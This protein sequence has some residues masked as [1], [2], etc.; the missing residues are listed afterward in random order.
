MKKGKSIF[1]ELVNRDR[2]TDSF[3]DMARICSPSRQERA[4][5]GFLRKEFEKLGIELHEDASAVKVGG[6]TGNLTGKFINPS[7]IKSAVRSIFLLAHLDTVCVN[8]DI[9]P[10]VKNEKITNENKN[11]ILGGDDKV[12]IAAILEA[13]KV[14]TENSIRS[15]DIDLIFTVA[16]EIAVLGAKFL[17]VKAVKSRYGFVF[18]GEGDI[19]TIFNRAPYHNTFEIKIKGRAAHAGAEPEKGISSIKAAANAISRLNPGRVDHDTTYNIGTINGG[20]AINIVPEYTNIKAEARSLVEEKLEKLS[21]EI[22]EVFTG[23]VKEYGAKI[24]I[25]TEREYD[26]FYVS[27]DEVPMSLALRALGNMGIKP[28]VVSTG[29]GSDINILNSRG[30]R[31]LNLS[32]GME[33]IHT[34]REYVKTGQLANLAVLIIELLTAE[35]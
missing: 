30:K 16:E 27:D 23:S 29:G 7:K 20:A 32:S 1:S 28:A 12:A 15:R 19:G 2:I 17:D 8:G 21:S 26:G 11:C 6:D 3:M 31:A 18:D 4:F 14:I 5:A 10:V 25:K 13:V 22:R 9:I 35:I 24:S 34:C 33:N